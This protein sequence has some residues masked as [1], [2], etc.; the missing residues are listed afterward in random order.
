MIPKGGQQDYI[1][2]LSVENQAVVTSG[3]YERYFEEDGETYIHI[4]NPR[5]G[6]PADGDLLSVTI[7]SKGRYTCGWNVHGSLYYGL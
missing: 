3:G 6:Y 1:G 4:I 5:T 2:V 7:V